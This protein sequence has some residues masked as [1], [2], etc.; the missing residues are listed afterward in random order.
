MQ[1]PDDRLLHHCRA[2]GFGEGVVGGVRG[3]GAAGGTGLGA[4]E[5][6]FLVDGCEGTIL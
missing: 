4:S 2:F 6:E 1:Q 3:E 5:E